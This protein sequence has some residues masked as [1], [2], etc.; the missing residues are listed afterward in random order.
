[1]ALRRLLAL[2]AAMALIAGAFVIRGQTGEPRAGDGDEPAPTATRP[3]APAGIGDLV[4][5]CVAEL[6]DVCRSLGAELD[7]AVEVP[8]AEAFLDAAAGLPADAAGVWMT[9]EPLP[10]MAAARAGGEA[11]PAIGEGRVL[12]R[13]PVVAAVWDDRAEVLVDH[14]GGLSWQCVGDATRSSGM[15][16]DIGGPPEWGP[17]KPAHAA[18]TSASGLLALGQLAHAFFGDADVRGQQIEDVGFFSWFS[19]FEGAVPQFS[20]SPLLTMVQFG[21][22]RLDVVSVIEADAVGLLAR[23]PGRAG[24]LRLRAIEPVVTA[25]VVVTPVGEDAGVQELA[26][27]V[28]RGS[29]PLLAEAGWRVGGGPV[30]GELGEVASDVAALPPA[31]GIPSGGTLE[32][33]RRMWSEVVR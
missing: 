25:D 27:A 19:A 21:S 8:S 4:L 15:W 10:A 12:A 1:V 2:V 16:S 18:P 30:E 28:V 31:N 6:E 33:L 26:D 24:T 5:T 32:A 17:I 20:G 29:A 9:I 11:G 13:S 22:G 3:A 7:V 23:S 14:C